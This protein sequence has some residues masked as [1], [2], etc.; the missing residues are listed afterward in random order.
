MTAA[1]VDRAD[2]AGIHLRRRAH[3]DLAAA[4]GQLADRDAHDH[5]VRPAGQ[6]GNVVTVVLRRLQSI[7]ERAR[8]DRDGDLTAACLLYTSDAAD[9]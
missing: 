1:A 9:E 7:D 8:D 5:T 3:G 6:A 2:G 4:V